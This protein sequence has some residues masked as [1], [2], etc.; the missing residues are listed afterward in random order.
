[1]KHTVIE[2]R[3]ALGVRSITVY[4]VGAGLWLTGGL[5]LI[6]H[7]FMVHQ[8][9]LGPSPDPLEHWWLATHGA[10]AFVSLWTMGLLWGVHVVRH[11]RA[12]RHRITGALL[13]ATLAILIV[14]GYL[15]YY[16]GG[17]KSRALTSVVHW[18]I[19][20]ALPIPFLVHWLV[21]SR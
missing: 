3:N 10:F 11:W 4:L 17:D 9:E 14:S 1:V 6:F 12:G 2:R 7:H 5:W 15:L 16:L 18:A 20:L 8:T 19:G 13:F 21:R